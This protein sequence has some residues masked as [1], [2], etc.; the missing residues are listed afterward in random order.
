MAMCANN[1]VGSQSTS[2]YSTR[3]L[4]GRVHVTLR[5]ALTKLRIVNAHMRRR[6]PSNSGF[7]R[8]TRAKLLE[9]QIGL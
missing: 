7:A 9:F 6:A 1:S 8:K 4:E 2:I 5:A 3:P